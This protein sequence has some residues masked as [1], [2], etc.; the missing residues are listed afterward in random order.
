MPR[1]HILDYRNLDYQG[2]ER[3]FNQRRSE[4][5][6]SQSIH[7]NPLVRDRRKTNGRR[8]GDQRRWPGF[9]I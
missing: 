4:S 8:Q 1:S 5:D 6:Y 7:L 2:P 9:E 3:R